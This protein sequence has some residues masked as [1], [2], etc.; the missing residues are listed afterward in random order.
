MDDFLQGG[1]INILQGFFQGKGDSR[2]VN[3]LRGKP[4][5]DKLMILF[6]QQAVGLLLNKVFYRLH[7][8][9]GDLLNVLHTA[10]IFF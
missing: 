4:E 7:V 10:G 9:I 5:V 8:M 1:I 2:I 3:I 6:G